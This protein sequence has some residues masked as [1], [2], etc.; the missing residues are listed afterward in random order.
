MKT[1]LLPLLFLI[2]PLI[3]QSEPP[4]KEIVAGN[5]QFS[6][7]LFHQLRNQSSSNLFIHLSASQLHWP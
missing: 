4:E 3:S 2:F 6:F 1:L 7:D 5:N